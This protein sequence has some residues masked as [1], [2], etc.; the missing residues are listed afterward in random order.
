MTMQPFRTAA[1][2]IA[3][4]VGLSL[5]VLAADGL[6]PRDEPAKTLPVPDTVSPELQAVIAQPL[7]DGWNTPPTTPDGWRD[8]AAKL[9]AGLGPQVAPMAERLR[10]DIRPDTIDGVKVYRVTPRDLPPANAH[11]LLVHVHGGCYVLNPRLAALP[12]A[13]MMAG[14]ARMPVIAVDY[15]M[16]PEAYFPAA[17]D[18]AETVYKA[19]IATVPPANVGVFGS[20]AGGALTLETVLRAK[21]DALPMPGAIAPGTPM[22]DATK[23]GDS[24]RTNALVDNVLVS[25]DG[26]CHAATLFYAQGHDLADPMLSPVYGDLHGFPPTMLTTGTR[27]LLLS[28]TVRV[29]QKLHEAGVEADLQ[30]FEGMAHAQFYRDDRIPE[31]RLA[32]EQLAGFFDRHLGR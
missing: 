12:E 27:D 29:Q 26:F 11:R 21:R 16:P 10:V 24:F 2:S 28:N 30:V 25:P 7:H 22:S 20:S 23:R 1:L 6:A 31:D 13:V 8:L 4:L 17:L 15:R 18:D 32:F 3:A 9:E 14:I 5:P 19:A